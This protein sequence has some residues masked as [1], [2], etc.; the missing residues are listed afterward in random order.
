MAVETLTTPRTNLPNVYT[1]VQVD[2][3]EL[4]GRF[5]ANLEAL[6]ALMGIMRPIRKRPG[7]TLKRYTASVT[8][9]NGNVPAGAVIPYSKAS[10]TQ[11]G[12]EEIT[13]EKY[14]TAT[15]IEEI[16]EYGADIALEKKKAQFVTE[17]Q[18][19][20][21]TD[22]YTF[23]NGATGL[24]DTATTWQAALAKAKGLVVDKFNRLRKTVTEVVGFANVLDAYD[25]LATANI[26]IQTAFGINYVKDF[27]GYSTLFLLSDPDIAEGTVIA[28]PVENINEYYIDPADGEFERGGLEYTTSGGD[29]NLIGFHMRG[30]YTTAVSELFAVM[31][32]KLWAEISDGIAN[33]T[34]SAASGD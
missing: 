28:V 17:L 13:L 20:I 2:A 24:S 26:T 21:L 29:T 7:T 8:L 31:G 22:F 15:T 3:I 10:L 33:V 30:N 1:N 9:E 4:A 25:Y 12:I 16:A 27:L 5:E 6:R 14:A 18:N 34:V 11:T 32:V 23:L 19:K